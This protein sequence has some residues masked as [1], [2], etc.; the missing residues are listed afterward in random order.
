MTRFEKVLVAELKYGTIHS[1]DTKSLVERDFDT[2][3]SK[4]K[5]TSPLEI[6]EKVK[7]M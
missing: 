7:G 4:W 3:K 5:T 1:R 2:L 6:I